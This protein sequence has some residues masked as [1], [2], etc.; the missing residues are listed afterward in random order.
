M[1][2]KHFHTQHD[3]YDA[4]D[5]VLLSTGYFQHTTNVKHLL[6]K[7]KQLLHIFRA[8]HKKRWAWELILH[9]SLLMGRNEINTIYEYIYMQNCFFFKAPLESITGLKRNNLSTSMVLIANL[10][11]FGVCEYNWHRPRESRDEPADEN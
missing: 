3:Y 8:I 10:W 7:H 11:P 6:F 2:P 1:I 4:D 9:L 5:Q